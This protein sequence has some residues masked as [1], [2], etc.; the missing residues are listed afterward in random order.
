MAA[1]Q[2]YRVTVQIED[3][4][5]NGSKVILPVGKVVKLSP[6]QAKEYAAC[7]ELKARDDEGDDPDNGDD[8]T[9]QE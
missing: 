5:K 4:D 2:D 7:V 3:R 1:T 9:P 6:A 8:S